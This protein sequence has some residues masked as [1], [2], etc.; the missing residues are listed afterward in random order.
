MQPPKQAQ[1]VI[2]RSAV[3]YWNSPLR[4]LR[5]L[6]YIYPHYRRT[7]QWVVNVRNQET[8]F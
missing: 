6:G 5:S 4:V 2:I 1:V 3:A 8:L 7:Y